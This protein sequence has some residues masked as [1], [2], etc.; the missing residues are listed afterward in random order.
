MNFWK[1]LKKPF[2]VLAPM[3][4]VTDTVFRRVILKA[5]RPEVFFTEFTSVEGL[6][7]RGR[8]Q[9]AKRLKYHESERPVVAQIWGRTPEK[10]YK[11]AEHIKELGFDAI[12]INMGCPAK[13]VLKQGCGAKLSEPGNRQL[14]AEIIAATKEGG[15][16]S[17]SV[18]TRLGNKQVEEGWMEFLLSQNIDALTV[19]GRTAKEM[20]LVPAKWEEIAKVVKLR[21]SMG[22]ETL[23]IGNG[24]IK[25]KDD[26][27]VLE[28]GVDGAMVGRGIFENPWLF[29][30]ENPER[31]K[32]L[33][34]LKYHL[35]LWSEVWGENKD[36]SILKKFFKIYVKGWDGA[37]ELRARMMETRSMSEVLTILAE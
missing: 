11:A 18:K 10:F 31:E 26:N 27:R 16:M 17:V 7:S 15:G 32:N 1:V 25:S 33:K 13:E 37:A 5:G 19:H 20:S 24:D 28:S 30:S 14:V 3:E 22:V 4:D 12:D 34:L 6:D 8:D 29:A 23:I 9:V 21:D 2:W 35:D 36:Y